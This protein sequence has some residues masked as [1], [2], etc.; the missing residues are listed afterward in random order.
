VAGTHYNTELTET[1]DFDFLYSLQIV[2]EQSG[3]Y[4]HH[5]VATFDTEL[6][7]W[8][9]FSVS[10]VWDRIEDPQPDADG[11]VPKQNDYLFIIALGIDI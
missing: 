4:T 3:T 5:M 10:A 2:N 11:I 9:D 8:L 1:V 7:G 6:T